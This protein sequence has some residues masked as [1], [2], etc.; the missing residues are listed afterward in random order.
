VLSIDY[1]HVRTGGAGEV[2]LGLLALAAWV[3]LVP[4]T[5]RKR[6]IV[7]AG[8]AWALV[9][10]L[11]VSNL[12]PVIFHFVA[13]RY[14]FVPSFGLCLAAA[15]AI[16]GLAE[17]AGASSS[18]ARVAWGVAALL[19]AAGGWR[20]FRAARTWR[21]N[22]SLARAAYESGMR[23]KRIHEILGRHELSAGDDNGVGC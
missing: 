4:L 9:M 6:P 7:S 22:A 15:A 5:W 18:R 14:L 19:V 13:E 11:P 8:L 12:V 23:T 2:A 1:P 3:A 17:S 16:V 21:D 20:S 10:W